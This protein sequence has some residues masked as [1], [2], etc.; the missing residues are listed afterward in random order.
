MQFLLMLNLISVING[1][2]KRDIPYTRVY[3][4]ILPDVK[5][6]QPKKR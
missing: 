5:L 3:V 1:D 4:S 2:N 6:G